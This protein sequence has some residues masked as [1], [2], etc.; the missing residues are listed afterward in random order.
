MERNPS[1]DGHG[2]PPKGPFNVLIS[3]AGRRVALLRAFRDSLADLGIGGRV[4][5]S[6]ASTLSAAFHEADGAFVVPP[7]SDP[8]F[9]S[10]LLRI[11]EREDVRL[12]VPT[13]DPELAPLAQ[14]RA[15]FLD[16]G[17]VVAVSAPEVIAIGNDKANTHA[18]LVDAGLPTVRQASLRESR[19]EISD[20]GGGLIVKPRTGSAGKGITIVGGVAQLPE[21]EGDDELIVQTMAPGIEHTV[22]A[23][24]DR[25]GGLVCAVPRRRLEV[26]SGESSKGMTVREPALIEV[27]RRLCAALPGAYA[28]LTIQMFLDDASGTLS[29]IEINPRFGGGF[30]LTWEAGGRYPQWMIEELLGMAPRSREGL[31]RDGV[32]MLRYD[33]AVFVDRADVGL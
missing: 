6:D 30:P 12:L 22:D 10:A 20:W 29:V 9:V 28:A 11:C 15:A 21:E 13:I 16:V 25:Q 32:V 26:R 27:V 2:T 8:S 3:S 14:H 17:T 18:F 1:H 31:W 19:G 7:C 5:A 23:L 4:L 33:D 24:V